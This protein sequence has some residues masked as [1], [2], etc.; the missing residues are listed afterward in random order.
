MPSQDSLGGV[1][2]GGTVYSYRDR[3]N[4]TRRLTQASGQGDKKR[5]GV[6]LACSRAHG[7]TNSAQGSGHKLAPRRQG[8]WSAAGGRPGRERRVRAAAM[9]S[10]CRRMMAGEGKKE[11]E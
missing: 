9:E 4:G 2:Y 11:G 7:A 10:K 3:T 5:A 6:R 1:E 8:N